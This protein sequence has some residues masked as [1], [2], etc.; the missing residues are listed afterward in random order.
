MVTTVERTHICESMN[1]VLI[2]YRCSGK[3]AVGITL[4]K[5]LE[6]EFVE[7]VSHFGAVERVWMKNC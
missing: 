4:A 7:E 2:G 6:R 5:A 1:I 3:T